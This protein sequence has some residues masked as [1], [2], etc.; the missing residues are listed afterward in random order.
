MMG[1]ITVRGTYNPDQIDSDG[2]G[3]GDECDY[4][5]D[6]ILP[7]S[8]VFFWDR[9][10]SFKESSHSLK[11]WLGANIPNLYIDKDGFLVLEVYP[12][13]SSFIIQSP[14]LEGFSGEKEFDCL[15]ILYSNQIEYGKGK[16]RGRIGWVDERM[17][18][19]KTKRLNLNNMPGGTVRDIHLPSTPKFKFKW[20]TID[21]RKHKNWK[22]NLKVYEIN[23]R[24]SR[25]FKG[26]CRE[27]SY[28]E[29]R[30]YKS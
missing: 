30:A 13:D 15:R 8:I 1:A 11:H 9:A 25:G 28:L 29:D 3:I 12:S 14:N 16:E 2:D 10:Y 22:E 18:D 19:K 7:E 5:E 26:W 4:K 24:S 23:L 20:I 17:I 6:P 21:L 27:V